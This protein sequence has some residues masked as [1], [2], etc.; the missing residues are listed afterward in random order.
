M[1]P[2]LQINL[3][4]ASKFSCLL[5]V[6]KLTIRSY[7]ES[8]H[9]RHCELK[10]TQSHMQTKHNNRLHENYASLRVS[11]QKEAQKQ[12]LGNLRKLMHSLDTQHARDTRTVWQSD[13]RGNWHTVETGHN[14]GLT[15]ITSKVIWTPD[16]KKQKLQ[17]E[18]EEK[19]QERATVEGKGEYA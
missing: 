10:G 9:A 1:Q 5:A 13:R 18:R 19:E 11:H 8:A 3:H 7:S 16:G 17:K 4:K 14:V 15:A 2:S 12:R 6:F